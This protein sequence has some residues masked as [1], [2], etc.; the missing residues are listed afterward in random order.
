MFPGFIDKTEKKI[1]YIKINMKIVIRLSYNWHLLVIGKYNIF[2]VWS[3]PKKI[4]LNYPSS[5]Q[6]HLIYLILWW[7]NESHGVNEGFSI[8]DAYS[9]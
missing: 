3:F 8:K 9:I 6:A 1:Y 2:H 4:K 7:G 5:D